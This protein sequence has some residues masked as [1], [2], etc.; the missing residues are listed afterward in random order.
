MS[1]ERFQGKRALVTGGASGI[2]RAT[3]RRLAD[4][5]AAVRIG[6]LDEAGLVETASNSA[7]ITYRSCDVTDEE[8]VEAFVADAASDLGGIDIV[9]NMA[10]VLV[11]E[12]THELALRDWQRVI[13]VNLTGTFLVCRAALPHLITSK[14]VIVNA[15]STAAHI[16]QPWSAAYCA[17]KGAILSLTRSLAVEYGRRGVRVNS[18]SPGAIET[19]IMDAF[20]FPEGTDHSLLARTMPLGAAGQPED[21]AAAIAFLASD[22]A[23]YL[24]GSDLRVDGATTA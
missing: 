11:F 12:N 20:H 3:A 21:A 9:V 16:G 5:G 18:V 19:P 2:G 1:S 8:S 15:A 10:G 6:D 13:D 23:H 7:G 4:E 22:E 14:G 24:N 17:S